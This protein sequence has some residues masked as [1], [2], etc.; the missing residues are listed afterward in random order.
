MNFPNSD[1]LVA[2]RN[3]LLRNSVSANSDMKQ[4]CAVPQRTISIS[5]RRAFDLGR[6]TQT[7]IDE[8]QQYV[9]LFNLENW[10]TQL[11]DV[12]FP[13]QV[14]ELSR[15]DGIVFKECYERIE[16]YNEDINEIS[17]FRG[18]HDQLEAC[19]GSF[20]HEND[21]G[22]FVKTSCRSAKDY[23]DLDNLRIVFSRTLSSLHIHSHPHSHSENN[24]MIAM[25]Y[26]SMELLKMHSAKQVIQNFIRSE[27]I[28]HDMHLALAQSSKWNEAIV[29]RQWINIEPD[30][31]FRCFVC[32][33]KLTAISQYRHL[34]YFPRLPANEEFLKKVIT[35]FLKTTLM[36]KLQGLF[37][38]D[39]YIIDL[40]LELHD[41]NAHACLEEVSLDDGHIKKMWA[42]EVNPF[43]D[44]TDACMF[45]WSRDAPVLMNESREGKNDVEIRI[46]QSP[47][48]GCS[49]LIYG[50]WKDIM[51]E[52]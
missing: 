29:V 12:T 8:Y 49:S 32:A 37:P 34:V 22:C 9:L 40:A 5:E 11:A 27:R 19:M 31:E 30:M 44:T 25:S 7:D 50:A 41:D 10:Y 26:A 47:A 14:L 39:D 42:V 51:D 28:W 45:S 43:Y 2:S 35:H 18:L 15:E 1:I 13:T 48:R 52:L 33:G 46:R 24:N 21:N 3:K 4:Q 6:G 16:K 36:V 23:A 17:T 20:A 38:R